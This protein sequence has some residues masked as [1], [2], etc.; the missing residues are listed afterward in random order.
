MSL[1]S[2]SIPGCARRWRDSSPVHRPVIAG[3]RA[4]AVVETV[5]AAAVVNSRAAVIW[6]TELLRRLA[7]D[8]PATLSLTFLV[9]VM[10]AAIAAPFLGL[11][12]PLQIAPLERLAP[13][14][15]PGHLLGADEQ[16]RDMLGRLVWGARTSLLTGILPVVVGGGIGGVLGLVA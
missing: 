10:L 4:T 12:D 8:R 5:D 1:T 15:S 16:G 2:R 3:P 13:P 14:L 7:R 9:L 11:K 6:R